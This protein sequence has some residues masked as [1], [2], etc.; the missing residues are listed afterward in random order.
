VKP[1]LTK[2]VYGGIAGTI[3]MTMMA[4]FVAPMM[5]GMPMDIAAMLGGMVGGI[6]MGWIAHIMM[7]VVVFPLAY[8]LVVY[9]FLPGSQL[10]RG[11]IF[12]VILWAMAV[13]LVMPMAGAGFLMA[14]IGGMMA[15]MASLIGHLVYGGLLG[16]IAGGG[17]TVE[18]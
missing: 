15:V 18:A 3:L 10:V 14:N 5:T 6:T 8:A 2:A 13:V 12:G 17:S 9:G 1:E 11:L 16:A 4:L 7:G